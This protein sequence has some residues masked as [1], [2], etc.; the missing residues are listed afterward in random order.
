MKIVENHQENCGVYEH[1]L[2]ILLN[3]IKTKIPFSRFLLSILLEE[4]CK[5][6]LNDVQE[7]RKIKKIVK[8]FYVKLKEIK[9]E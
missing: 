8:Y 1:H 3:I 2:G 5:N 6:Q 9:S 4:L 7:E